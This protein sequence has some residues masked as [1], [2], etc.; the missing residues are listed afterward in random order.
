MMSLYK[1]LA[2]RPA[3]P[4]YLRADQ[5]NANEATCGM[6]QLIGADRATQGRDSG[7]AGPIDTVF[8]IGTT[9]RFG[10]L[11][12]SPNCKKD[13]ASVI[14]PGQRIYPTIRYGFSAEIYYLGSPEYFTYPS[15]RANQTRIRLEQDFFTYA[16]SAIDG[17][18]RSINSRQNINIRNVNGATEVSNYK[19]TKSKSPLKV[20]AIGPSNSDPLTVSGFK[21][22]DSDRDLDVLLVEVTTNIGIMTLPENIID[23][24][25]KKYDRS[26]CMKANDLGRFVCFGE[27]YN[28]AQSLS[29]IASPVDAATLLNSIQYRSTRAD[30]TDELKVRMFDGATGE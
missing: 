28:G 7:K 16:L 4:V 10:E 6:I 13:S 2:L 9:T 29:F 23:S 5:T 25:F 26:L 20:Q 19:W 14:K 1:S 24:I 22:H 12:T 8:V 15:T 17:S 11:Y 27:V 21:T 30:I 3:N 18:T